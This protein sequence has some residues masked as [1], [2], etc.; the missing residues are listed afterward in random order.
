MFL[1]A[2]IINNTINNGDN[3]T[4]TNSE[5][6]KGRMGSPDPLIF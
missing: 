2:L 5:I 6:P 3:T 4:P 1:T